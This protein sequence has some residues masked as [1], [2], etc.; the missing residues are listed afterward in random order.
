MST[1]NASPLST[2]MQGLISCS[3]LVGEEITVEIHQDSC[4]TLSDQAREMVRQSYRS[5]VAQEGC[6]RWDSTFERLE[7]TKCKN[8]A[9]EK[10]N[11]LEK[12]FPILPYRRLSLGAGEDAWEPRSNKKNQPVDRTP[13]LP[14]RDA[15]F[16]SSLRWAL[17]LE[18][19]S[20]LQSPKRCPVIET[21]DDTDSETECSYAESELDFDAYETDPDSD[22]E[23]E[24]DDEMDS[25]EYDARWATQKVN[26]HEWTFPANSILPNFQ[27][28]IREAAQNEDVDLNKCFQSSRRNL[29]HIRQRC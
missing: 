8:E 9:N 5:S 20:K 22:S 14:P 21:D 26:P 3:S 2:F 11:D 16:R 25:S 24:C 17:A 10:S 13:N 18:E 1:M 27:A 12:V 28:L 15:A 19:D 6:S 4:G 23:D 29:P 7:A